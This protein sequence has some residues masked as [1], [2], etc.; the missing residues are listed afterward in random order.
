[1]INMNWNEIKWYFSKEHRLY[2]HKIYIDLGFHKLWKDWKEAS[3]ILNLEKPK[4]KWHWGD[5]GPNDNWCEYYMDIYA[6]YNDFKN[7]YFAIHI[8]SLGWRYKFGF[9]QYQ[10]RPEIVIVLF[11][12]VIATIRLEEP[13]KDNKCSEYEYWEPIVQ[14]KK[15]RKKD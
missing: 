8:E 15:T 5:C 1:M 9:Y 14:V 7:K 10:Y 13:N 4:L 12:K 11:K 2:A 6:S 3:K